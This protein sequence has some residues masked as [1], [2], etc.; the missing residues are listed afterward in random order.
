MERSKQRYWHIL[1][2][3]L[4]EG[5]VNGPG[6][7]RKEPRKTETTMLRRAKCIIISFCVYVK[8]CL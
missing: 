8:L 7:G 4:G 1:V 6:K 5:D 3:Y 2:G